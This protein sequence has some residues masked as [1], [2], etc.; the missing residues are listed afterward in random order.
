MFEDIKKLL[1]K[2]EWKTWEGF[3][4]IHNPKTVNYV[5]SILGDK[6]DDEEFYQIHHRFHPKSKKGNHKSRKLL[7]YL[8]KVKW[9]K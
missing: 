6:I 3:I 9:I 1:P 4:K 8:K 7:K 5:Y 2:K